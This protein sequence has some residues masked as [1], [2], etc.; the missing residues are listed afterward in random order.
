MRKIKSIFVAGMMFLVLSSTVSAQDEDLLKAVE[1]SIQ[2]KQYVTS[3]FK[4]SRVIN[5]H[6]MEMIGKRVLDVRFL[7]RFGLI[8]NG[9]K[10]LFG[11]DQAS[12]R[13]GFDY[14][15]LT[16]LTVGVGRSSLN[17]E[18]DGFVKWRILRQSRGERNMPFSLVWISGATINTMD[19]VDQERK[20]YFSSRVGYFHEVII[21]RKFSEKFS[22]QLS[23]LFV[24][25]NLVQ[26]ADEDNDTYALGIGGRY[27]LSKRFAVVIDY[28]PILAGKRPGTYDPF[29]VGVD[30]ETGGH[31][32]QLHFTN[33]AG[34]NER[35]FITNTTDDFWKG[36]IRFG[37]NLSRVFTLGGKKNEK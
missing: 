27:K 16:N 35:E 1:D 2:Q 36:D 8:S 5:G 34:M 11:L 4:S 19:F 10:E 6:S 31:V 29:S 9:V 28:H 17:K 26:G 20:N 32:F 33:S 24:N 21:G 7:H 12:T 23:P 22:L 15:I 13:I 18:F 3:A 37:F 30:I 14:G 25:R